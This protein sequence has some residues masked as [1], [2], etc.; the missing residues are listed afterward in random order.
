MEIGRGLRSFR[1]LNESLF[2]FLS[3]EKRQFRITDLIPNV[4]DL[5]N[6]SRL[7]LLAISA[8][9]HSVSC[10]NIDPVGSLSLSHG[11]AP[12]PSRFAY[13]ICFSILLACTTASPTAPCCSSSHSILPHGNGRL[14][15]R[16]NCNSCFQF[17]PDEDLQSSSSGSIRS[18]GPSR[19]NPSPEPPVVPQPVAAEPSTH[20]EHIANI[21][22]SRSGMLG[23]IAEDQNQYVDT[24]ALSSIGRRPQRFLEYT[25]PPLRSFYDRN[26]P[27]SS[28]SSSSSHDSPTRAP[29]LYRHSSMPAL[30]SGSSLYF[31]PPQR[32]HYD[33]TWYTPPSGSS[34]GSNR[35][36]PGSG[37][38]IASPGSPSAGPSSSSAGFT[39]GS[40]S[41]TD[42]SSGKRLQSSPNR[43]SGHPPHSSEPPRKRLR[44]KEGRRKSMLTPPASPL[45][46][47]SELHPDHP[48]FT[49][50]PDRSMKPGSLN[51]V[52]ARLSLRSLPINPERLNKN[53][54][55]SNYRSSKRKLHIRGSCLGCANAD[56]PDQ[57]HQVIPGQP[58]P[59]ILH[60]TPQRSSLR[61]P[62]QPP[63]PKSVSFNSVS[64]GLNRDNSLGTIRDPEDLALT[65]HS[66]RIP[67]RRPSL[68]AAFP[69]IW[70]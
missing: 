66:G 9:L 22:E 50:A 23:P 58:N 4:N 43:G 34:F 26:T 35:D 69:E 8:R 17:P 12:K 54:V 1:L 16:G 47:P 59:L 45:P 56:V 53:R 7:K 3:S 18:P 6:L 62:G 30:G 32:S 29:I 68:Q 19:S 48:A 44:L 21:R 57:A 38:L 55:L 25:V 67:E 64:E 36:S 10:I 46:K 60:P 49:H 28:S 20:T 52:L 5:C 13:A 70:S 42:G 61:Q 41:S 11:M 27:G 31:T 65:R 2:F 15:A 40:A 33:D 37:S 24:N 14:H 63:T 39:L 51:P